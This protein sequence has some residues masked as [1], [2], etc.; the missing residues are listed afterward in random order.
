MG[1]AWVGI[2]D[3]NGDLD[4]LRD[5]AHALGGIAPAIMGPGGLGSAPV[6]APAVQ[7][8]LKDALDPNG[9]LAP[10]RGWDGL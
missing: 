3:A 7:R 4:T 10:G 6:A 1:L 5:R 9:V 8:R 2:E